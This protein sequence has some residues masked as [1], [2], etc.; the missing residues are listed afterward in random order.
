[1]EEC[2][3]LG[4]GGADP[5]TSKWSRLGRA[6]QVDP[7]KPTLK[8]PGS[9]RLILKYDQLLSTFAFK[10]NSRHYTWGAWGVSQAWP[11]PCSFFTSTHDVLSVKPLAVVPRRGKCYLQIIVSRILRQSDL[12]KINW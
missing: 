1:V 8:A 5:R 10:S 9:E 6:V 7:I 11:S 2:K 4:M 12:R 3:P